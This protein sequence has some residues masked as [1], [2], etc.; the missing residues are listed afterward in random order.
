MSKKIYIIKNLTD[1]IGL[2]DDLEKAKN[3]LKKIYKITVGLKYYE[4]KIDVYELENNRYKF[5]KI[6]YTYSF[7]N[8]K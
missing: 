6:S 3:E 4:Y 7:N 8:F 2:Y 5:S 1:I